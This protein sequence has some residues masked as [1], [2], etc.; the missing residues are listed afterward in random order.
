MLLR[1]LGIH[2]VKGTRGS[3]IPSGTRDFMCYQEYCFSLERL[4]RNSSRLKIGVIGNRR[5]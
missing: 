1:Q 2:P 5:A 4:Q 3:G